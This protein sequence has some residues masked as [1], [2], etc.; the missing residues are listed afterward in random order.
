MRRRR[1]SGVCKA[2]AQVRRMKRRLRT[3]D[4]SIFLAEIRQTLNRKKCRIYVSLC[5]KEKMGCNTNNNNNDKNVN[6]L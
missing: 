4:V 5:M 1:K 3:R 2:P 6:K